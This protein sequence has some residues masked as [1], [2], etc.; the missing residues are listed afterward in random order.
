[1]ILLARIVPATAAAAALL[2]LVVACGDGEPE[3]TRDEQCERCHP[4]HYEEWVGSSHA[5]AADDPVFVAMNA[6]FQRERGNEPADKCVKCHAPVA[7]AEGVTT[8]GLDLADAPAALR[9]VTCFTCHVIEDANAARRSITFADDGVM[10]GSIE[11]PVGTGAHGSEYSTI[12]DRDIWRSTDLCGACH[13]FDNSAGLTPHRT[14]TE[15]T[16]SLFAD[17]RSVLFLSCGGCHMEGRDA[18]VATG[19][20]PTRRLHDH[21]L[22]GVNVALDDSWP[23]KQAQLEA[24]QADLEPTVLTRLC[25]TADVRPEVTLDNVTGGHYWPSGDAFTRRAWVEVVARKGDTVLY[26]SGVVPD[27]TP[28]VST[29]GDDDALWLIRDRLTDDEDNEVPF[30]WQATHLESTT[31]PGAVT[32]DPTDPAFYHAVTRTYPMLPD[33]PDTMTVRVRIRPIGLDI[34]DELIAGGD[35]DSGVRDRIPTFTLI[36]LEWQGTQ[37]S[38]VPAL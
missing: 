1:M 6:R 34:I 35:L 10:R 7:L 31:L 2:P 18:P 16:E 30:S 5:Y 3:L 11:N 22:V 26:E 15:W 32:N 27:G 21:K 13:D 24:I 36:D 29:L 25:L 28:V 38:C 23:G 9:G 12:L 19:D 20:V 33:V 17:Q 8:D 37:G 4:D 14:Y